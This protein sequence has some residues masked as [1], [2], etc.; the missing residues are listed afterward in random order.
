MFSHG[1][2][3]TLKES[4]E[5]T[6]YKDVYRRPPAATGEVRFRALHRAQGW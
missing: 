2:L 1:R 6:G 3:L 5:R 4:T